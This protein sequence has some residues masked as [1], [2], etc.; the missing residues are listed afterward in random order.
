MEDTLQAAAERPGRVAAVIALS[1]NPGLEDAAARSERCAK[2]AK[3]A[4]RLRTMDGE[5]FFAWLRDEWY[6]APLWG[7][8]ARHAQFGALLARRAD[9]TDVSERAIA[10]ELSSDGSWTRQHTRGHRSEC[11]C[12]RESQTWQTVEMDF[13]AP[14]GSARPQPR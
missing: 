3:L 9:G 2:D 10:L 4:A 11:E 14:V 1:G 12:T 6:R 13:E 8:L 7:A 5:Q